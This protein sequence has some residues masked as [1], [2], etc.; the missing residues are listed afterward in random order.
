MLSGP[1]I[2]LIRKGVAGEVVRFLV[3]VFG[4]MLLGLCSQI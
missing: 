1:L 2:E 4:R 3:L